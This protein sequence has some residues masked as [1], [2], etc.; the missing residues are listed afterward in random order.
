M[1][2]EWIKFMEMK[3]KNLRALMASR[4]MISNREEV[5]SFLCPD[6]VIGRGLWN[7]DKGLMDEEGYWRFEWREDEAGN[8]LLI[9]HEQD[10]PAPL[11]FEKADVPSQKHVVYSSDYIPR[12]DGIIQSLKGYGFTRNGEKEL[13]KVVIAMDNEWMTIIPAP[14]VI[15]IFI[16][17]YPPVLETY[18]EL[19]FSSDE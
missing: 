18:D 2:P 7:E 15:D 1:K 3:G 5:W 17:E 4:M 8:D 11:T 14:G 19:V 10:T 12:G 16:T 13:V 9:L 6:P